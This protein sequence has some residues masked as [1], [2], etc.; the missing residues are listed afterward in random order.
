MKILEHILFKI[1]NTKSLYNFTPI[2]QEFEKT[3]EGADKY[4]SSLKSHKLYPHP[5]SPEIVNNFE[6]FQRIPAELIG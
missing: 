4:A 5:D 6:T 1:I 3:N 2:L